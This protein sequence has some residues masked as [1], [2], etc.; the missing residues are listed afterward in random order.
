M[1]GG[2]GSARSNGWMGGMGMD[3]SIPE[4]EA[5]VDAARSVRFINVGVPGG[6]SSKEVLVFSEVGGVVSS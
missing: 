4:E 5:I 2:F 6:G 1:M 3:A